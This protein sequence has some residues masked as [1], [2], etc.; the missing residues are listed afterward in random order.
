MAHP[1]KGQNYHKRLNCS[2]L[3]RKAFAFTGTCCLRILETL[4][5]IVRCLSRGFR[6]IFESFFVRAKKDKRG[7]A[8]PFIYRDSF[9]SPSYI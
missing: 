1:R 8:Y 4:Y 6:K 2:H 7:G 9:P 5:T 3:G